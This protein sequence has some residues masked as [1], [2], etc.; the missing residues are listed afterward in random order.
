MQTA[1]AA[2]SCM[3][4]MPSSV[5]P[6]ASWPP[7][8]QLAEISDWLSGGFHKLC[9]MSFYSCLNDLVSLWVMWLLRQFPQRNEPGVGKETVIFVQNKKSGIIFM[10]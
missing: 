2:S 8:E 7:H 10:E 6:H 9:F 3:I 5:S 4:Y 1:S